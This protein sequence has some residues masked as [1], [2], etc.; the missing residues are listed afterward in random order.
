MPI[1]INRIKNPASTR[2]NFNIFESKYNNPQEIYLT[3]TTIAENI[4]FGVNRSEIDFDK[5]EKVAE[6]SNSSEFIRE[7]NSGF[8]QLIGGSG[9][10]LSGGQQQRLGLARALYNSPEVL[11]L[12]EATSALDTVTE[13]NVMNSIMTHCSD[14]TVVSV[15]HNVNTF[16]YFDLICIMDGGRVLECGDVNT[17][18]NNSVL[19]KEIIEVAE[20]K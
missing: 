19:F 16:R 6:V 11:V 17:L 5:L 14:R 4:A 10:R 8:N 9:V 12:D 7:Y 3:N 15:S 20:S 13:K 1:Q 18:K 2:L